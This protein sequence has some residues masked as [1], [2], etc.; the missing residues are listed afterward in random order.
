[1]LMLLA[2]FEFDGW[3][4]FFQKQGIVKKQKGFPL[5]PDDVIMMS[6]NVHEWKG[7]PRSIVGYQ[8]LMQQIIKNK[9][10]MIVRQY[11]HLNKGL[12]INCCLLLEIIEDIYSLPACTHC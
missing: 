11:S 7:K 10:P 9:H 1:M 5:K 3:F 2:K 12:T 8:C 4:I 6:S